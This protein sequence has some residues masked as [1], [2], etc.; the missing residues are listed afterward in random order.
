V[1]LAHNPSD[2]GGYGFGTGRA[3][4]G[5]ELDA[6]LDCV[7]HPAAE[8]STLVWFALDGFVA[9][10]VSTAPS[11]IVSA[12]ALRLLEALRS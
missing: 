6:D 11:D 4:Q 8:P 5:C 12:T 10:L 3:Q 9:F 2:L 7:R 1:R